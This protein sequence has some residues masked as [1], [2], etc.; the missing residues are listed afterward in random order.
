MEGHRGPLWPTHH[1]CEIHVLHLQFL[2]ELQ[3]FK[4]MQVNHKGC[5]FLFITRKMYVM[6]GLLPATTKTATTRRVL[7]SAGV[8]VRPVFVLFIGPLLTGLLREDRSRPAYKEAWTWTALPSSGPGAADMVSALLTA[9]CCYW[10][11]YSGLLL[12]LFPLS[13]KSVQS[14]PDF[15]GCQ[16]ILETSGL[17]PLTC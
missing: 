16:V 8:D 14:K 4:W 1:V 13:C 9:P 12:F 7:S 11:D 6:L 5:R 3:V 15:H 2:D 17:Q 10:M